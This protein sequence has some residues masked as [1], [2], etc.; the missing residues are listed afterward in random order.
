MRTTTSTTDSVASTE[1]RDLD[2]SPPSGA[3]EE[4]AEDRRSR[5]AFVF[6]GALAAAS[7]VPRSARAQAR[8]RTKPR[9]PVAPPPLDPS[10]PPGESVAP[11]AEWD[12]T[13]ASRLV[14]R[15]TMGVT[16]GEMARANQLGWQAYLNSQLNYTR[17]NDDAT[18]NFVAQKWPLMSQTSDTLFSADDGLVR[19][20]LQESTLY[21]SAFSSRQ[22]YHRMVE[23][24]SDHFNQDIDKVGYLLVADQRDVIRKNALGKFP[25]L[26]KASA[27][28]AS[29][30]AYLD[31][32]TSNKNAPNQNYAR[33]IMELHTLGVDGGYTQD[34]VAE[35]S[36][37]LT[38]WT[39]TGRGVFTFN[40][41]IHDTGS[42]VVLGTTISGQTGAAGINEGEQMLDLLV[43]HPSTA[44]FIATKMLKWLLDPN[45]SD[46]Q[47]ATVA[48]VYK[49]TGGDIKAMIRVILND[50]WLPAAPMKF[51]RPFHFVTSAL[52][53]GNPSTVGSLAAMNNQ[54]VNLGHQSYTWETP[55][56]YPDRIE[57]WS[58][59]ILPRWSFANTF[60]NLNST[61]TLVVDTVPYRA[62][63]TAAAI[64]M[65]NQNFFGGEIPAVTQSG[66]TAYAGTAALTDAKVRELIALAISANA[67]QWY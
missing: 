42:K 40:P 21:R 29:M 61:S 32:N 18:E 14:R 59:N 31:Q 2:A 55:D 46:A 33:E 30:M 64:E 37:V 4:P 63:S 44:K 49:A 25:D 62:G 57:Y 28:S 1:Q 12:V 6:F 19:S 39:I 66:L 27:H 7:L 22:L 38:G 53:S 17:I 47:I 60:S 36:R 15:V 26:L 23:F 48:S 5:R 50:S 34:D 3:T 11:F 13:S 56:G 58:G 45:P 43:N 65:I 9:K 8:T 51:K 67:Y 52:R 10:V 16:P 35:L 54:L 24:W 20:Q 41:G